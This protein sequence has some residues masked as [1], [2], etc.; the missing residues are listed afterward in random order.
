M[1][2]AVSSRVVL[3]MTSW[4]VELAKTPFLVVLAMITSTLQLT[5]TS[6]RLV[7]VKTIDVNSVGAGAV[8]QVTTS[9]DMDGG[10]TTVAA[11]DDV[12]VVV[13]GVT[14][15]MD[16]TTDADM[17]EDITVDFIA[18]HGSSILA[19]HGV[20]VTTSSTTANTA[21]LIFTGQTDGTGFTAQ[22]YLSDDGTLTTQ[23]MVA[24]TAAVTASVG[25]LSTTITDFSTT[26]IIDTAGLTG[27]GTGGYYEGAA[28]SMTAATAYGVVVLTGA[29]YAT[30]LASEDAV[31][32]ASTSATEAVVVYMN[33]T[34]G[35]AAAYYDASLDADGALGASAQMFEFDD[36]N[37]LTELAAAFSSD[38]FTI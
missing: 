14:Y 16:V 10:L 33:S 30:Q 1:T 34:T 29:A 24:T 12:I 32:I 22:V 27:L 23:T 36:I 3:A 15:K 11:E 8:A 7:L 38:S 6:L 20:T 21:T 2:L 19:A 35:K 18:Q 4:L 13:D 17:A 25:D 9:T 28:G 31:N 37:S 26:D 5:L